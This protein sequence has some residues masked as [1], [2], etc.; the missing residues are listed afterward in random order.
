MPSAF[1]RQAWAA[2]PSGNSKSSSWTLPAEAPGANTLAQVQGLALTLPHETVSAR[3]RRGEEDTGS[4][5]ASAL[6]E[7]HSRFPSGQFVFTVFVS[8]GPS[9]LATG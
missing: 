1:S 2:A 8:L 4:E 6:P 9:C 3:S 5:A 7:Q